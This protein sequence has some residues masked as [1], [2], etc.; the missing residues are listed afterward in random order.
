M[1]VSWGH[2]ATV[3]KLIQLG[4]DPNLPAGEAEKPPIQVNTTAAEAASAAV[5]MTGKAALDAVV[6][7]Q[8][9]CSLTYTRTPE[10]NFHQ[11]RLS[12]CCQGGYSGK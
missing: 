5:W 2:L 12:C 1:A 6:N 11:E 4:A 3:E 7:V 8:C 10:I 9:L